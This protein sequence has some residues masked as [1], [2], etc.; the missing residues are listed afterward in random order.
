MGELIIRRTR[1]DIRLQLLAT[2]S[3]LSLLTAVASQAEAKDTGRPTLWIELGGQLER[4]DGGQSA[5]TVP[6]LTPPPSFLT[7][8][9]V[10]AQR[11]GRYGH[12]FQGKLTFVPD[13]S[14]WSFSA[15]IRFGRTNRTG[16][17]HQ[18]ANV[19]QPSICRGQLPPNCSPPLYVGHDFANIAMKS[20]ASHVL[21]DF[22]A[23]KDVGL[24]VLGSNGTSN[25]S[26]GVRFA[27]FASRSRVDV[28]GRPDF[29]WS[30][31]HFSPY[32]YLPFSA[33]HDYNL[34]GQASRSFSGIGPSLSWTADARVLSLSED[35]AIAFDWGVNGALLFGRQKAKTQQQQTTSYINRVYYTFSTATSAKQYSRNRSVIV[36]NVGGFAGV[37]LRFPNAKLSLGYRADLFFGAVD[38]GIDARKTNDRS[39][40]GPFAAISIGLGG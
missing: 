14:D 30:G 12:G 2:V 11:T 4:I 34:V 16:L 23:G 40:Y 22:Q 18:S 33:F 3:A 8:S 39:F 27:Q 20:R 36:P 24:G 38:G 13:G 21:L 7:I 1:A 9:P 25:I 15:A 32:W 26:F 31:L 35:T 6:F 37:S 17:A 28:R 5:F 29:H 10:E 19:T